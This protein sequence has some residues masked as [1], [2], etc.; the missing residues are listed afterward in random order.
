[1]VVSMLQMRSRSAQC[2]GVPLQSLTWTLG[3]LLLDTLVLYGCNFNMMYAGISLRDGG[4]YFPKRKRG[5]DF[6]NPS[7]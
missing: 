4:S 1:M 7:R 6:V 5:S 3:A 2:R